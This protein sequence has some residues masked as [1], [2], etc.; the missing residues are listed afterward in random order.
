ME[1]EQEEIAAREGPPAA[2]GRV[3][4]PKLDT[5]GLAKVS[6]RGWKEPG[7]RA[8]TLRNPKLST[9]WEKKMKIKAEAKFFRGQK[10]EA[11]AAHGAKMRVSRGGRPSYWAG[12]QFAPLP[13]LVCVAAARQGV[14]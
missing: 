4:R 7:K 12:R 5:V 9:G 2:V 3:K 14:C 1:Q 13:A 6:G 8:N 11:K 10:L